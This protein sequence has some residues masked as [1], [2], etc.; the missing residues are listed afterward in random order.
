V[1]EWGSRCVVQGDSCIPAPDQVTL[2]PAKCFRAGC[3]CETGCAWDGVQCGVD[4][5]CPAVPPPGVPT[6]P[7]PYPG[8]EDFP[9]GAWEPADGL[10]LRWHEPA[11]L[12][13]Q[14]EIAVRRSP[15]L[16]SSCMVPGTGMTERV[17]TTTYDVYLGVEPDPPLLQAAVPTTRE[18]TP[19]LVTVSGEPHSIEWS[20]ESGG[21][22]LQDARYQVPGLL[23][24]ETTYFWRIVVRNQDGAEVSSP[25]W[26]F[27]T[28]GPTSSGSCPGT[29]TVVDGEGNSYDT[30]QIGGQCW[31]RTPLR[32]GD[33][34]EGY[35]TCQADNGNVEKSCQLD[36]P[37]CYGH[38]TWNEVLQYGAGSICP[39]GWRLP[40]M[41]DWQMLF[42]HPDHNRI[43]PSYAGFITY[44]NTKAGLSA[45]SYM[46]TSTQKT[47][48]LEGTA[49]TAVI[50]WPSK[51]L[52]SE[53]D[54]LNKGNR[55][56]A[57]CLQN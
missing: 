15:H 29:P 10:T 13:L 57:M 49:Y 7:S 55:V 39:A 47:S 37:D 24:A 56:T 16:S 52:P 20:T 53:F 19:G 12:Y 28:A 25:V 40:S 26:Q 1:G 34:C 38:Y 45:T 33:L 23:A 8:A 17:A 36:E 21:P 5:G 48:G 32:L 43:G 3:A 4:P 9:N 50:A 46:W 18:D 31:M 54:S 27:K 11:E 44:S 6:E 2:D 51:G 22:P 35:Y 14:Y 42:D 41:A 30:A